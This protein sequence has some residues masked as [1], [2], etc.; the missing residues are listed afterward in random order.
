MSASGRLGRLLRGER[1]AVEAY[2]KALS[3]LEPDARERAV[4]ERMAREHREAVATLERHRD[5][6]TAGSDDG[7]GPWGAFAR[8]VEKAASWLGDTT[9][10]KALKE[11][12]VHGLSEYNTMLGHEDVP[13]P[14]RREIEERLL[15]R[16][17]EHVATLDRLIAGR[18]G[19]AR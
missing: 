3:D 7:S 6:D 2:E 8:A 14:L 17:E 10:L 12:E 13:A 15:P 18:E 1:A 11:G 16:Q 4:V 5:G 19:V 9:A